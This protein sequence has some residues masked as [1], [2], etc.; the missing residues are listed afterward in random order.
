MAGE[1]DLSVGS[2]VATSALFSAVGLRYFRLWPGIAFGLLT[3]AV[4]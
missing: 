3:G 1:I 4:F 2:V